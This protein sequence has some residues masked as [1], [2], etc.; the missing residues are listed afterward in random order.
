[1]SCLPDTGAGPNLVNKSFLPCQ[2]CHQAEPPDYPHLR[3]S[4]KQP[5]HIDKITP[6]LVSIADLRVSVW[7]VVVKNLGVDLLSGTF[8]INCCIW[9]T[10]PSKRKLIPWLSRLVPILSS[11]PTVRSLFSDVS[12]STVPSD[13]AT[14][15]S[16]GSSNKDEGELHLRCLSRQNMISLYSQAPISVRCYGKG[17]TLVET[18]PKIVERECLRACR[19]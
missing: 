13:H 16:Q 11:S 1:M 5:V 19:D 18:H 14:K 7:L 15:S 9:P 12:V 2:W 17:P 6:M 10:F 3:T 8:L 4:T